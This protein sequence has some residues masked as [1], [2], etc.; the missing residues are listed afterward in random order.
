[1][2]IENKRKRYG[3]GTRRGKSD[4]SDIRPATIE[5]MTEVFGSVEVAKEMKAMMEATD[6]IVDSVTS[7]MR[8]LREAGIRSPD[9]DDSVPDDEDTLRSGWDG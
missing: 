7:H 1:M 6:Q 4:N 2:S 3:V 5:N 8:A 9:P